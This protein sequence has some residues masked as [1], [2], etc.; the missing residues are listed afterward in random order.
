M[1]DSRYA[2]IQEGGEVTDTEFRVAERVQYAHACGVAK[3]PKNPG[4]IPGPCGSQ[5]P[6][7]H[8]SERGFIDCKYIAGRCGLPAHPFRRHT[9]SYDI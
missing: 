2:R 8:K 7:A 9:A 5:G 3:K 6:L 1:A 4:Q